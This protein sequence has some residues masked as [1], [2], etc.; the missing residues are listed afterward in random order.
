MPQAELPRVSSQVSSALAS[1]LA[2]GSRSGSELLGPN[3][4]L[5]C[6]NRCRVLTHLLFSFGVLF[7]F[8]PEELCF[9]FLFAIEEHNV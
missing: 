2:A 1:P 5:S 6:R 4:L 7:L 3:S 9:F 8:P